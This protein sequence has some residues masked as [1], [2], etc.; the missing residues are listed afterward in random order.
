MQGAWLLLERPEVVAVSCEE[1][2]TYQHDE[3]WKPVIRG[4]RKLPLLAPTPC[5]MCPKVP[6]ET[7]DAARQSGR[8]VT[9]DDAREWTPENY[10]SWLHYW[11]T[12]AGSAPE[13]DAASREMCA[14]LEQSLHMHGKRVSDPMRLGGLMVT[15]MKGRR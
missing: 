9:R 12:K 8:K 1:C 3:N 13:Q 6:Q 2:S 5:G 14:M 7:K 10:Q 11:A 15:M 4:G